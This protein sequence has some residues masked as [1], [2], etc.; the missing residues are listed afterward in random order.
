MLDWIRDLP[1][2]CSLYIVL[3]LLIYIQTLGV[4][5]GILYALKKGVFRKLIRLMWKREHLQENVSG[6]LVWGSSLLSYWY[7]YF[8]MSWVNSDTSVGECFSNYPIVSLYVMMMAVTFIVYIPVYTKRRLNETMKQCRQL[9]I[10]ITMTNLP[11]I[12]PILKKIIGPWSNSPL[13]NKIGLAG[14]IVWW[15]A[16]SH[17]DRKVSDAISYFLIR[18]S[19]EFGGR[20]LLLIGAIYCATGKIILW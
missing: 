16:K 18:S 9:K 4:I 14:I 17:I 11:P 15:V 19:L 12:E 1:L 5:G 3:A 20:V 2:L 6:F 13:V 7:F 8:L 10:W